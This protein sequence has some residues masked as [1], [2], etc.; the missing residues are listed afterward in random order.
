MNIH[1]LIVSLVFLFLGFLDLITIYREWPKSQKIRTIF[2]TL[3]ISITP[4]ATFLFIYGHQKKFMV[5]KFSVWP[6]WISV[7]ILIF[8]LSFILA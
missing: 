3:L 6:F 5:E 1:M 8:I 4:Y 7:G 2:R